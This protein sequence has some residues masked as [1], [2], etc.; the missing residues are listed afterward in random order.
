MVLSKPRQ[1]H[2]GKFRSANTGH[3]GA[4]Q[5]SANCGLASSCW[6]IRSVSRGFG[7]NRGDRHPAEGFMLKERLCPFQFG[8]YT[9]K[10]LVRGKRVPAEQAKF[11]QDRNRQSKNPCDSQVETE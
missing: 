11:W 2:F 3:D 4:E 7:K 9:I 1:C 8:E 6:N 10:V 5:R